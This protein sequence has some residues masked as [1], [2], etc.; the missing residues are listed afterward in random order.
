MTAEIGLVRMYPWNRFTD[1]KEAIAR[2]LGVGVESVVVGHGSE[3]IMQLIPML[4]V[5]PGDEVVVPQA[6]YSRYAE[7]SK[8]MGG[9][10]VRVPMSGYKIDVDSLVAA[11]TEQ[12]RL[13][14]LCS[15]NNPTGTVVS[16]AK[17]K[18]LLAALPET[19]TLVLDQ[20]YQEYADLD[21]A[22]DG[23]ALV[24]EGCDKLVV[25]RTFSKA[26]G[27]AGVR[28]G[29]GLAGEEICALLDTIKEPFNLNRLAAAA[30]PA[31]MNDEPWLSR[32]VEANAE[33]RAF[34]EREMAVRGLTPVSSQA[35]FILVDVGVEAE[36]MFQA[37]M[38][39]GVLVRPATA[40]GYANHIRVTIGR[41][42][43]N[44]RFLE[45]LDDVRA[46]GLEAQAR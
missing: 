4:F 19:A 45:A 31:A 41:P 38:A 2:F 32:C 15:P 5:R 30:G 36:H 29:Y 24:K 10:L 46:T 17:V 35:N 42:E 39:R 23:A 6:T 7:V 25:L 18:R 8:V 37:L 40:W 16:Q 33:Q 11:L 27:L 22:C 44:R 12:T 13:V 9:T 3:A 43:E 14:W 21:E 28:L 1:L 26:Y 20:A 34:L